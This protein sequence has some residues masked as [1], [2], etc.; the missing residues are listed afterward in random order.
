MDQLV[1]LAELGQ[2]RPELGS[3]CTLVRAFSNSFVNI[4]VKIGFELGEHFPCRA[5]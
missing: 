2:F 5:K 1:V 3:F 4:L